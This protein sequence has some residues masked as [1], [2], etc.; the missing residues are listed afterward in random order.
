MPNFSDTTLLAI[1]KKAVRRINRKLALTGTAGEISIDNLGCITPDDEDLKD[2]VLL[3]AECMISQTEFQQ[4][5]RDNDAGVLVKDGE[6]TV[7]TRNA[8]VARGTF[9]DSPNS[10]CEEL[11]ACIAMEQLNRACGFNIW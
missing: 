3:Q 8:G 10:P 9:F 4:D 6:Q 7:D 5:L 1:L 2:L 11:K